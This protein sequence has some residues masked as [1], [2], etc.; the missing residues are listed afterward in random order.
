MPCRAMDSGV[1]VGRKRVERLMKATGLAGVSR[2]RSARTTIRDDRGR[3]S[4]DLVDRNFY[5]DA[6]N[7][8]W[9]ADITYVLTCSG[10]LYLAVVLNAF[11][12]GRHC[13]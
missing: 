6:P 9:V 8:L 2:R 11:S 7:V 10:F 13:A 4:A 12:R 3:P 5:A 1:H